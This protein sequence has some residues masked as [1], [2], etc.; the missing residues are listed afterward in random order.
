MTAVEASARA[1]RQEDPTKQHNQS[2][3]QRRSSFNFFKHKKGIGL[4]ARK[5]KRKRCTPVKQRPA[6]GRGG[7]GNKPLAGQAIAGHG[8]L[9][10][11]V[12]VQRSGRVP[13]GI[14]ART[15]R[16]KWCVRPASTYISAAPA[17][18]AQTHITVKA[19]SSIL[20]IWPCGM[21]EGYAPP[22]VLCLIGCRWLAGRG[23]LVECVSSCRPDSD[24][25]QSRLETPAKEY[26]HLPLAASPVIPWISRS[27]EREPASWVNA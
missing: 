3:M 11:S 25:F 9:Q 12:G 5:W 26:P 1:A 23:R 22:G 16:Q 7:A 27:A 14:L 18:L 17:E 4:V 24:T 21:K 15:Q 20:S 13:T 19:E 10:S 2:I 6:T 8:S